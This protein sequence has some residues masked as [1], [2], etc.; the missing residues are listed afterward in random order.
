MQFVDSLGHKKL[1]LN[2]F[3]LKKS[4]PRFPVFG[5]VSGRLPFSA[6]EAE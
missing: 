5:G 1:A 6:G 4:F 3:P 2:I